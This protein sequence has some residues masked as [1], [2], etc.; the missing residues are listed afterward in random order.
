MDGSRFDNLTR[1]FAT[2]LS[3]RGMF[4]LLSGGIGSAVL[5]NLLPTSPVR[6]QATPS[7]LEQLTGRAF[8]Q[9]VSAAN[10]RLVPQ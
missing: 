7:S 6:A 9:L 3:R 2:R 5:T 10:S 4:R 1:T 8:G